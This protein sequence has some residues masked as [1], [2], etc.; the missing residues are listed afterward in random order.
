[1]KKIFLFLIISSRAFTDEGIDLLKKSDLARG[2]IEEGLSWTVKLNIVDDGEKSER[3]FFVKVKDNDSI[4]EATSPPR[5]KGEIYLFNNRN[6]WFFKPSLKKPIS[7]SSR[8]RLSG[9]AANGDIAST[10]Y[11]RDYNPV[12]EKEDQLNGEKVKILMLTSKDHNTT[13][14]KIRYYISLKSKYGVKAEFLTIQ[15]KTLKTASFEYKNKIQ[16]K[17]ELRPFV[18]KMII[19]DEINKS[20]LSILSYENPK[21]AEFPQS[22]FN[23]NSIS[24]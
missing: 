5:N 17:G 19:I 9:Q 4:A 23:V 7:L 3:E 20:N 12:I 24:R 13:Y 18:S 11:A 22:V 2:G 8:Q 14:D 6:M 16:L 10:N 1:M 21:V 15:G